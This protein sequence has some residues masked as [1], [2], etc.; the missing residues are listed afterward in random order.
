[1]CEETTCSSGDIPAFGQ[2]GVQATDQHQTR[3]LGDQTH[4]RA[5]EDQLQESERGLLERHQPYR[6]GFT[7]R[8]SNSTD[9]PTVFA[10]SLAQP[11]IPPPA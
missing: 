6:E 1:M 11:A 3:A 9:I 7:D 2:E 5:V 4:E 10:E 8:T